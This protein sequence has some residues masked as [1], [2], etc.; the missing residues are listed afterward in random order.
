L[1]V[2]EVDDELVFG[3]FSVLF[4]AGNE[5]SVAGMFVLESVELFVLEIEVSILGAVSVVAFV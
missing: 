5:E 4:V 1:S 2:G 3:W